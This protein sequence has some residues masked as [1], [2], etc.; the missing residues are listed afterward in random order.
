MYFE[1]NCVFDIL[2]PLVRGDKTQEFNNT[3]CEM[4][5]F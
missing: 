2:E 3:S 4:K 5:I 1:M